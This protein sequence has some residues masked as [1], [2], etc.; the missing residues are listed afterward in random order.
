MARARARSGLRPG[1]C[2]RV[3]D[4]YI[5]GQP[6]TGDGPGVAGTQLPLL[7][8]VGGVCSFRLRS[9]RDGS[10]Q[11]ERLER[12]MPSPR[13]RAASGLALISPCWLV[14]PS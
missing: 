2:V 5:G 14:W 13:K 4:G 8:S 1:G 6:P 3:D 9:V 11:A 7:S 12:R 10:T